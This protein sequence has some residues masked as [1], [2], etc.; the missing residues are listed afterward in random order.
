[1]RTNIVSTHFLVAP[2]STQM[3]TGRTGV[4]GG[5]GGKWQK[6]GSP[7]KSD[8]PKRDATQPPPTAAAVEPVEAEETGAGE[9]ENE[10]LICCSALDAEVIVTECP[11]SRQICGT[12]AL[13]MRMFLKRPEKKE[14]KG[15]GSTG[16]GSSGRG[17]AG[18][19]ATDSKGTGSAPAYWECP[20]CKVESACYSCRLA[21]TS[22]PSCSADGIA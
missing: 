11:H 16:S 13:R 15:G 3:S 18:A 20:F 12:C 6:R 21:G 7:K 2:C 4:R 10:C 17:S 1:M 14:E 5:R 22:S 19:N 8:H 9:T